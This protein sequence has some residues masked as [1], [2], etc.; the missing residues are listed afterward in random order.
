MYSRRFNCT[1]ASAK[2]STARTQIMCP[3]GNFLKMSTLDFIRVSWGLGPLQLRFA[4]TTLLQLHPGVT[5]SAC[6]AR[7]ESRN[8]NAFNA[9]EPIPCPV[10]APRERTAAR[11]N[12][13]RATLCSRYRTSPYTI[14][15]MV[16]RQWD[17][18]ENLVF[19]ADSILRRRFRVR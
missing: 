13:I 10:C 6:Q 15:R 17:F 12:Y 4:A 11:R 1:R 5:Q 18:T 14:A 7:S 9:E 8:S 19:G 2:F 3:S 16:Q